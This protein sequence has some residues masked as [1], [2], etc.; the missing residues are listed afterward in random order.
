MLTAVDGMCQSLSLQWWWV[1]LNSAENLITISAMQTEEINLV[2]H[3]HTAAK[4]CVRI[5]RLDG[6]I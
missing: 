2:K 4:V 3:V 1:P 5:E 6:K